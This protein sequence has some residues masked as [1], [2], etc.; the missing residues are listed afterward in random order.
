MLIARQNDAKI[1]PAI[2]TGRHPYLFTREL[3]TGPEIINATSE[4]LAGGFVLISSATLKDVKS[5][6]KSMS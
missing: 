3:V 6:K 4:N 1:A 5:V 2:V